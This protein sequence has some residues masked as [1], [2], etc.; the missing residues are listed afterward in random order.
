MLGAGSRP[1][2]TR[3]L[4]PYKCT[5][6]LCGTGR[7]ACSKRENLSFAKSIFYSASLRAR[8][9]LQDSRAGTLALQI[10]N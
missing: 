3:N 4:P 2:P 7:K 10:Q 5:L 8:Y 6:S 1:H 9:Q